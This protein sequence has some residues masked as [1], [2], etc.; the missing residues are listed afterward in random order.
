VKRGDA[1]AAPKVRIWEDQ[2]FDRT[3]IKRRFSRWFVE[4]SARMDWSKTQRVFNAF[5][6]ESNNDNVANTSGTAIAAA[7]KLPKTTV[8]EC[9]DKLVAK[10]V[11]AK[12]KNNWWMIDPSLV[13]AGPAK[14][15]R[16][17][18]MQFRIFSDQQTK[19]NP[20]TN[21]EGD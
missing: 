11:I 19:G 4:D 5:V 13:Y 16:A 3:P 12:I 21:H 15:H 17:A 9:I 10:K 18:R 1:T 2:D 8:Y 14:Y 20:A 6:V 7:L